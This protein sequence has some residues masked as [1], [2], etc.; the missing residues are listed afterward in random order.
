MRIGRNIGRLKVSMLTKKA[1]EVATYARKMRKAAQLLFLQ[2]HRKPGVKGWELKKA[3]G[4]DY[5]K[6]LDILSIELEKLGFQIKNLSEEAGSPEVPAEEKG[7]GTR[8]F[9][10]LKE[11][12][13]SPEAIAGGWRIDDIAMLAAT[14]AYIISKQGKAPRREVEQMLRDKFPMWR[15]ELN[16]ER[17]IRRGYLAEDEEGVLCLDW[18]ARSEIDSKAL[19][20]LILGGVEKKES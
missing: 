12:V 16:L 7:D 14:V 10:T 13:V 5:M 17:F 2:R 11:P 20:N 15:I 1:E 19:L 3:I 4:K 8:F 9:V 6:V 18:R